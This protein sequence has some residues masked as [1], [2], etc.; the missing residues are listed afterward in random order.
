MKFP[1]S[2]SVTQTQHWCWHVPFQ[3]PPSLDC[4]L[5]FLN[6][7]DLD[8]LESNH[9]SSVGLFISHLSSLSLP[10][11]T[12]LFHLLSFYILFWFHFTSNLPLPPLPNYSFLRT[13]LCVQSYWNPYWVDP[14]PSLN[15]VR[16][17][18]R[19]QH[20]L[21]QTHL[22]QHFVQGLKAYVLEVFTIINLLFFH[23]EVVLPISRGPWNGWGK[24][25]PVFRKVWC[26]VFNTGEAMLSAP[27]VTRT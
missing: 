18:C 27:V 9:L 16:V 14:V 17:P 7:A 6:L 24:A 15:T 5:I 4:L 23:L 13:R 26:V 12:A 19:R 1:F 21:C 25:H 20:R 10:N 8:S 11:Y 2:S 22:D 3:L